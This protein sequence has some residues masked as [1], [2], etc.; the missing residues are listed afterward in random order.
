MGGMFVWSR[1]NRYAAKGI[2]MSQVIKI[3]KLIGYTCTAALLFH[4]ILLVL[5]KFF[6][7]GTSPGDALTTILT[8]FNLGIVLGLVSW[9]L[10]LT[11]TI[12]ALARKHLPM[13]YKTWRTLHGIL[14]TCFIFTS[15][16]HVIDL[17]RNSSM[18][19]SFF[20]IM[21]AAG[22]ILL[23]SAH[24]ILNIYKEIEI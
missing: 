4:P 24:L 11:I 21:L 16:W 8:T 12:T 2:Q 6:E 1:A 15:A 17:G 13:K 20:I 10:L 14:A 9:G 7:A 3:H 19:M 5:P 18:G 23:F 22:S